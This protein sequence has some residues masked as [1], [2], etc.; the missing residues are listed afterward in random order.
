MDTNIWDIISTS[1]PCLSSI[2][3][4]QV[5]PENSSLLNQLILLEFIVFYLIDQLTLA[6]E[7][8]K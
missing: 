4:R 3:T 7:N 2:F 5:A 8:R 1:Q 6:D